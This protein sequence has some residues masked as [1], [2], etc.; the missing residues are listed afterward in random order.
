MSAVEGLS[1]PV[2]E[3]FVRAFQMSCVQAPVPEPFMEA[4]IANSRRMPAR[5]WK[6]LLHGLIEGEI[7]LSRPQ[8]RTLVLGGRQ[9][10][11]FSVME[12]MALAR[13]FPHGELHLVDG[14]GHSLHWEQPSTFV[15]A[16]VR[17][18]V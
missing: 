3:S 12:Q 7:S 13:Q 15:S 4:V 14:V 16:L 11:I 17:F 9:D 1:D 18:G 5:I 2:D 10:A 6:A 8:V